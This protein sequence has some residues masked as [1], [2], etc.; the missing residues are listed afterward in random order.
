M[1]RLA[2]Y[3]QVEV[4]QIERYLQRELGR[5]PEDWLSEQRIIAARRLLLES[6]SIKQVAAELKIKHVPHFCRQFKR[7][8]G[9]TPSE[10]LHFQGHLNLKKVKKVALG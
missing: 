4:R 2:E 3:F 5:T 1:K 7:Y 8:Y 10:F 9:M 6:R